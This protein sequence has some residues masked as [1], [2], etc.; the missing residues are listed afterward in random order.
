MLSGAGFILSPPGILKII[1]LLCMII[2]GLIF[3]TSGDC[4]ESHFWAVT[5]IISTTVS[6][7]LAM[8]S[9]TVYA[10]DLVKSHTTIKIQHIAEITFAYAAFLL[11]LIVSVITMT[12][13]SNKKLAIDHV[14]EPLTI[15]GAILLAIGGTLL[16]LD[17]RSKEQ[18]DDIQTNIPHQQPQRSDPYLSRK[19]ILI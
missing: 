8:L 10:L 15:I 13:C 16:F 12:Q 4:T 17:W 5:Y 7:V 9:Y 14:P 11:L 18:M 19:S 1:S 3:V 2:G 6:A